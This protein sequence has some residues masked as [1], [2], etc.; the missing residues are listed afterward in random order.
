MGRK[1]KSKARLSTYRGFN[2]IGGRQTEAA[3]D[4][5]GKILPDCQISSEEEKRR[6]RKLSG[7]LQYRLWGAAT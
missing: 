2:A 4:V 5:E 3:F 6:N 1:N 7:E